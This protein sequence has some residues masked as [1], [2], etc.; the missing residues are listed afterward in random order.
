MQFDAFTE[1][2]SPSGFYFQ[3]V[4]NEFF[5]VVEGY[6][7][8][9]EDSGEQALVQLNMHNGISMH[10][11]MWFLFSFSLIINLFILKNLH[12]WVPNFHPF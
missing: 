3:L 6:S 9:K 4:S 11:P 12:L 1:F 10:G 7:R 8:E 5:L 2:F